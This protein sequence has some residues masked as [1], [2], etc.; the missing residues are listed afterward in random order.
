M[1]HPKNIFT[2]MTYLFL[3]SHGSVGQDDKLKLVKKIL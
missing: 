1:E 2:L 3:W